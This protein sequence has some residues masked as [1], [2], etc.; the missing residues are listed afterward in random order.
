MT[1][2]TDDMKRG[3]FE[4]KPAYEVSLKAAFLYLKA[5]VH[6]N[7]NRATNI[8]SA[9]AILDEAIALAPNFNLAQISKDALLSQKAPSEKKD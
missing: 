1:N 8:D 2:V 7:E 3:F 5:L 6:F 4:T 9:V